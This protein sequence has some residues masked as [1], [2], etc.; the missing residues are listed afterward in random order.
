MTSSAGGD[1]Q[2]TA[3]IGEP[4]A[5]HEEK[6]GAVVGFVSD[7]E[8]GEATRTIS[9]S[10]RVFKEAVSER[11]EDD[12]VDVHLWTDGEQIFVTDHKY[13][14]SPDEEQSFD[15]Y[16]DK[17]V[18]TDVVEPPEDAVRTLVNRD[19]L[20]L[21]LDQLNENGLVDLHVGDDWLLVLTDGDETVAVA[22]RTAR[23]KLPGGVAR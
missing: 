17:V 8:P 15:D 12:Y 3:S 2:A 1:R 9:V 4:L 13:P 22:P 14:I 20:R 5:Q 19:N 21:A 18:R 16:D 10:T 7:F 11:L 6:G 23:S